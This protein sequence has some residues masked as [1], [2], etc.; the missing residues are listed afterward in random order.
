MTGAITPKLTISPRIHD[1]HEQGPL[2]RR[3]AGAAVACF[4]GLRMSGIVGQA[5]F[6]TAGG[7]AGPISAM[8]MTGSA[9][10][11]SDI[12]DAIV[13]HAFLADAAF[14]IVHFCFGVKRQ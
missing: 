9:A 12:F 11:A 14:Q 10:S 4:D 5:Q 7:D 3:A 8:L 13:A 2:A 6:R 1:G